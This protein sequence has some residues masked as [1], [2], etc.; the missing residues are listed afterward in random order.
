MRSV[1]AVHD[2]I[3][4]VVCFAFFFYDITNSKSATLNKI[5]YIPSL[6]PFICFSSALGVGVGGV[7]AMGMN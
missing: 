2:R 6:S 7:S 3:F 1:H 5:K 4:R